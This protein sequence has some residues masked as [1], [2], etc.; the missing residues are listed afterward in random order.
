MVYG[1]LPQKPSV[2][3]KSFLGLALAY[4]LALPLQAQHIGQ[5][6]YI[7]VEGHAEKAL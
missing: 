4:A 2:V 6:P 1:D 3:K 7:E 5:K